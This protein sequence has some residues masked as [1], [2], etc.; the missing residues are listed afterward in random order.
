[1]GH[2]II[3]MAQESEQL[4][5]VAGVD[6][7]GQK[8]ASWDFPVYKTP[9]ECKEEADAI[10]DFSQPEGMQQMLQ[11]ARERKIPMVIATTGLSPE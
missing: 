3:Q 10:I 6:P 2:T 8:E 11:M 1:M 7:K 4:Q 9:A 5:V